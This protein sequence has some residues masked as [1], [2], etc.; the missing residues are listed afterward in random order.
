MYQLSSILFTAVPGMDRYIEIFQSSFFPLLKGAL[1]RT[2]PLTLI[3]FTI[4]LILAVITA[5]F[6]LSGSRILAGIARVYVSIIRGTPLLVQLYIIFFGL[7][8]VGI[9]IDPFPAAIIGF[10]LNTGAYASEIIRA[11]ILSI[12]KGQWEAA[13]SISMS[14]G[15]ALRRII[16]PQATRVSIPPLSNSFIGLVKNTSLASTI[17][18]T[19]MFRK[20]QEIVA[21]TYEPLLLYTEAALLYWVICFVLS[22]GQDAIEKHL[23]RYVQT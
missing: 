1:T 6:R 14:Y 23:N 22:L 10:S 4:G 2:I 21:T 5:L 18:V 8:S 19:E 17:M 9:E 7:G 20:S 3:A 15:Q 13:H 12:P 16:L 11:A